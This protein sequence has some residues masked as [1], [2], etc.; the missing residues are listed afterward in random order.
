MLVGPLGYAGTRERAVVMAIGH[1][2]LGYTLVTWR[3]SGCA[4]KGRCQ[5]FGAAAVPQ[6][7]LPTAANEEHIVAPKSSE[8]QV[9][10]DI[11]VG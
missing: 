4:S 11:C 9:P 6:S 5:P 7:C 3:S 1:V 8:V 10:F 2:D